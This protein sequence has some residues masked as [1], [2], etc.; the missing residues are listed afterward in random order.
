MDGP[1]R[2]GHTEGDDDDGGGGDGDDD[3]EGDDDDGPHRDGHTEGDH[4]AAKE[5]KR[6]GVEDFKYV[7][8]HFTLSFALN[9]R[10]VQVMA[11]KVYTSAE[12]KRERDNFLS[13]IKVSC[14][15]DRTK[16]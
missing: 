11:T 4:N 14:S 12:F 6:P 7:N 2:D 3:G 13:L 8:R 15:L 16:I 10:G 1:R 5:K 9:P